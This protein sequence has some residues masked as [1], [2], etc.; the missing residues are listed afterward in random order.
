MLGRLL[1][2]GVPLGL[3]PGDGIA[4]SEGSNEML[5]VCE[6]EGGADIEGW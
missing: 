5:G 1:L 6:S 3:A 4:D 2:E